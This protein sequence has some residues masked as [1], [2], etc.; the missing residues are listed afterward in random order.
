MKRFLLVLLF[1]VCIYYTDV[2]SVFN[3]S[4]FVKGDIT[5]ANGKVIN[6]YIE[7][8]LAGVMQNGVTYI[9]EPEY[10]LLKTGAKVKKKFFH[11]LKPKDVKEIQLDNGRRF[12]TIKYSDLTAVKL[13]TIPRFYI[14]EIV[15]EGK[16]S[17]FKKYSNNF[18]ISIVS[19]GE[20]QAMVDEMEGVRESISFEEKIEASNRKFEIII[21]V[22]GDKMVKSLSNIV[23]DKYISDNQEVYEKYKS[24]KYGSINKVLSQLFKPASF[25]DS[26][27]LYADDFI[28]MIKD[29][30]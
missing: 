17:V 2:F 3:S 13:A 15:E 28:R 30:N 11:K 8:H 20:A 7:Y 10:Q 19:G 4:N 27:P 26:H 1:T 18:G 6:C 25:N 21:H 22:E 23:I 29:Y 5:L 16:I 24:G 14:F 9:N 12:K